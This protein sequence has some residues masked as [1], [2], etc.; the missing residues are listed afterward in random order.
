VILFTAVTVFHMAV[1]EADRL[2][3]N[4][5]ILVIMG[6]YVGHVA[7]VVIDQFF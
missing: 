4:H 2:E 7:K 5:A 6:R 1:M 3:M